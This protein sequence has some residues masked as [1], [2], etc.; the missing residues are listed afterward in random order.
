MDAD[1]GADLMD[2]KKGRFAVEAL[3]PFLSH[4][5]QTEAFFSVMALANDDDT[6]FR[7]AVFFFQIPAQ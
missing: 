7:R 3:E 5:P 1:G 6:V 4:I 2:C